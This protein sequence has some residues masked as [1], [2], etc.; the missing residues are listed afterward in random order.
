MKQL[1]IGSGLCPG[2]TGWLNVDMNGLDSE[3]WVGWRQANP[4]VQCQIDIVADCRDLPLDDG[5]VD[6]M[7]FGHMLEHLSYDEG[8]P[9]SLRE[10][11]R[12]LRVGGEIGVVGPAMDLALAMSVDDDLIR[13]I[14][15]HSG[16]TGHFHDGDP[17]LAHCWEGTSE[18]TLSL[19]LS[20]FSNAVIVPVTYFSYPTWPMTNAGMASWQVAIF[21]SKQ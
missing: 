17:G 16:G 5:T 10:A 19:V 3:I 12:V 2:P 13:A 15:D 1:N 7:F 21:A 4:T 9:Q 8:A 11:F 6:R 20:V 14:G 18:N